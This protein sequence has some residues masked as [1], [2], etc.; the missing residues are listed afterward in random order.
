MSMRH[1]ENDI[2]IIPPNFIDTGTVFG[3][4]IKLR[5]AAEALAVSLL[6]GLP[7]F[8]IPVTLTTKIIIACLTVL[9]AA[10]FAII[11]INGESLTSFVINFF[12]YLK[13]RR[14]VGMQED[15]DE[16]PAKEKTPGKQKK[17]KRKRPGK[18]AKPR[19]EDFAEEFGQFRERRQAKQAAPAEVLF[20]RLKEHSICRLY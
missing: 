16:A 8:H 12:V 7:V 4:T 5:N 14:V 17:E 19:K 20:F 1:E 15:A 6:I 11:G 9:P 10:L 18:K 2:Y 3:G 13:N